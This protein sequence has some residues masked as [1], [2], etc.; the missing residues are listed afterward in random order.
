MIEWSDAPT[1][2]G[3]YWCRL[4]PSARPQMVYYSLRDAMVYGLAFVWAID[5]DNLA[6]ARWYGPLV[7]PEGA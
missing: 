1:T 6:I 4:A 2:H 3:D 5:S 7:P